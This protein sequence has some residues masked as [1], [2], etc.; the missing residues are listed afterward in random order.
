MILLGLAMYS[1]MR[2]LVCFSISE[3]W[4]PIGTCHCLLAAANETIRHTNLR[5]SWQINQCQVQHMWR[6]YLQIDG[7][8]VDTLVDTRYP[9]GLRFNFVF[10]LR[11]VIPFSTWNMMELGPF[12]LTCYAGRSM[13]KGCSVVS[14]LVIAIDRNVDKLEDEWSSSNDTTASWEKVAPNDVF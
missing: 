8:S 14:G 4:S 6:E 5:Q 13:R 12:S 3:G 7:L 1:V 10:H 11:K 2:F 9:R